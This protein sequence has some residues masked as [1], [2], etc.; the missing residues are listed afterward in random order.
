V[1]LRYNR[2]SDLGK[3]RR[4]HGGSLIFLG[5]EVVLKGEARL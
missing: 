2:G 5:G 1:K 4:K 3:E